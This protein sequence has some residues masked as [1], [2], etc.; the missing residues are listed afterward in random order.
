MR[1]CVVWAR[2]FMSW[3]EGIYCFGVRSLGRSKGRMVCRR[4]R[5]QSYTSTPRHDSCAVHACGRPGIMDCGMTGVSA[6]ASAA[7][8]EREPSAKSGVRAAK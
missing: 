5:G 2:M 4:H 3:L 6:M 1:L 7:P 8:T